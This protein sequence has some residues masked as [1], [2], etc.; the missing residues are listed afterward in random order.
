MEKLFQQ[1]LYQTGPVLCLDIGSGTQ[2]A[3]LARPGYDVENWPCFVLPSPAMSISQRLREL[4]L[5]KKDVWLCGHIMGAGFLPAVAGLLQA[6]RR[7][8]ATSQIRQALAASGYKAEAC[9]LETSDSRPAGAVP[10]HLADYSAQGWETLLRCAGLP[11]PHLVLACARDDGAGQDDGAS[12]ARMDAFAALLGAHADPVLWLSMDAPHDMARL[13]ALQEATGGPVTDSAIAAIIGAMTDKNVR[14]RSLRQG[15]TFVSVGNDHIV[16]AL[17]YRGQV[18]GIYEHHTACRTR[19]ELLADLGEFRRCFLPVEAVQA[20][21]GHGTAYAPL[22]EEAGGYEP[23]FVSGSKR[24]LLAGYGQ[25]LAPF[26]AMKLAGPL[27]LLYG[28]SVRQTGC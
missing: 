13:Q 23:T 7:V 12:C 19:E 14:A 6:G 9:G 8:Y 5:L 24:A 22:C 17:L 21:G 16:A 10:V 18:H 2:E 4:A 25:E 27:G 11:M 28:Y 3:V 15:V 26:G 1:F 20:S